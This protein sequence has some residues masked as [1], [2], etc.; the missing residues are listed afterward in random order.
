MT[1][2]K[3]LC[4]NKECNFKSQQPVSNVAM[5]L[6]G[7]SLCKDCYKHGFRI[8]VADPAKEVIIYN[9]KKP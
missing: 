6:N 7:Y 2:E 1:G 5:E 9:K 3:F 4:T 8:R